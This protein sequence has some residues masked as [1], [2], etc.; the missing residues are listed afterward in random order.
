MNSLAAMPDIDDPNLYSGQQYYTY[1]ASLAAGS[2]LAANGSITLTFNIDGQSDF[3]WDKAGAYVDVA[4]DGTTEANALVPGISVTI[5]DTNNNQPMM[6]NPTPMANIFGTGRLPFILPI[7]YIFFSKGTV[8]IQLQ[9]I[10]DNT[11]YT[12]VDL[13]F[14]GIKAYLK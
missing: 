8:K 11:T 2:T 3:F 5:T 9:N 4:N 13:S 12:R 14:I 6:N 7:R 10:T 1:T